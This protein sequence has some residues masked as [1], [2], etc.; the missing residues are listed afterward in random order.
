M[1]QITDFDKPDFVPEKKTSSIINHSLAM[2]KGVALY[3]IIAMLIYIAG[4]YIIQRLIGFDS[5]EMVDEMKNNGTDYYSFNYFAIPG[6]SLYLSLSGLFGLLA[7]PLYVGLLYI[8]DK[9]RRREQAQFSDL[10]IGYRHNFINIMIF[11]LISGIISGLAM[12]FCIVPFFFVYPFLMLGYPVLLFENAS[13]GEAL[14]RSV[15]L[16]K[17]NYGTLLATGFV[18]M[19]LSWI[20]IILCG[21]GI[22]ATAP[23]FAVVMYSAYCACTGRPVKTIQR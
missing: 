6:F 16:A 20:G 19:L 22:V 9:Y 15:N 7:S 1:A 21:I 14:K 4:S 8:V 10:F 3:G 2:Y 5:V 13:A 18:G 12:F 23:F 11:T 17:E